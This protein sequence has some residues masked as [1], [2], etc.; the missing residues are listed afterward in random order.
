VRKAANQVLQQWAEDGCS[1]PG[2]HLPF[3]SFSKVVEKFEISGS[4]PSAAENKHKP[5]KSVFS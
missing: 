4:H 5:A 1:D 2:M 3:G